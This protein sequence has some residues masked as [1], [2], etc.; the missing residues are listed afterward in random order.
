M[1]RAIYSGIQRAANSLWALA[2]AVDRRFPERTLQ[3]KWAPAP[4]L[5]QRERS[6][7]PLGFPRQTDSLCP[8]CVTEVR[9]QILSGEVDWKV[10]IEGNPGEIRASSAGEDGSMLV[11]KEC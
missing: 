10:L 3:P 1:R 6:F 9:S 2:R 11:K 4:L 7:P 5:K 8:R